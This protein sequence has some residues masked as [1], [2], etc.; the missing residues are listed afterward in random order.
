M[1]TPCAIP[2]PEGRLEPPPPVRTPPPP[3]P[4]GDAGDGDAAQ[5][6]PRTG[7]LATTAVKP[8]KLFRTIEALTA[9]APSTPSPALPANVTSAIEKG[10]ATPPSTPPASPV[11]ESEPAAREPATDAPLVAPAQNV[12]VFDWDDTLMATTV[13]TRQYC[14]DVDSS[15]RLPA[16]LKTQLVELET[17]AITLL[18]AATQRCD[19]VV[20][21][22][23]A[24][25]GWIEASGRRFLPRVLDAM[26]E[27]QIQ[28]I[29][30]QVLYG[31]LH[32]SS[33]AEW[34]KRAFAERL[35]DCALN[36]ISIG[37]ANYERIAAKHAARVRGA[38]AVETVK[39]VKFV[40]APSL[41]KLQVELM[42]MAES[43]LSEV[44]DLADSADWNLALDKVG[45]RSQGREQFQG[46][47]VCVARSRR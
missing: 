41:E 29:S 21:I 8:L 2:L 1:T 45:M 20:I 37:D 47:M 25:D 30:A 42:V 33:P 16:W 39:T 36:L 40:E 32:P 15:V 27:L 38:T 19:R 23:N 4:V 28:I 13:L 24:G 5:P 44:L 12:I 31:P 26:A 43:G 10:L 22:T 34:K 14:F 18:R 9:A 17:A 11:P 35:P 6:H 7:S 3:P 46:R